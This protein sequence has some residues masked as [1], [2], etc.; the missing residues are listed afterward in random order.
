MYAKSKGIIVHTNEAGES[1]GKLWQGLSKFFTHFFCLVIGGG[2]SHNIGFFL[3]LFA[4]AFSTSTSLPLYA[5]L[6]GTLQQQSAEISTNKGK[7][8]Q[9]FRM[10]SL[11]S[12]V[13]AVCLILPGI[14]VSGN[15]PVSIYPSMFVDEDRG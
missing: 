14:L 9:S 10:L 5:S 12:V 1:L 4:F 13:L 3:G 6:R 8:T 15:T 7:R 2:S 11:V